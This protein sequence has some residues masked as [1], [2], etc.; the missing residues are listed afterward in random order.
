M[1]VA[2]SLR[3][4]VVQTPLTRLTKSSWCVVQIICGSRIPILA[5]HST[6]MPRRQCASRATTQ[7]TRLRWSSHHRGHAPAGRPTSARPAPSASSPM[8]LASAAFPGAGKLPSSA[9][10]LLQVLSPTLLCLKACQG[11]KPHNQVANSLHG[12][13]DTIRGSLLADICL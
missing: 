10:A 3:V 11:D 6:Q 2:R 4:L 5:A 1:P 7:A 13:P 9:F 12:L 8:S